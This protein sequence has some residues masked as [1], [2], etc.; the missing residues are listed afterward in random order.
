MQRFHKKALE[1]ILRD[2]CLGMAEVREDGVW[3]SERAIEGDPSQE[4][5]WRPV[6]DL[7]GPNVPD[8]LETPCLPIPFTASELAAFMLSG[9][10]AY[11]PSVYGDF[12][13]GPD[14]GML[15]SFGP[16]GIKAKEAL[17]TAY[18]AYR[19]AERSA[20]AFDRAPKIQADELADM[21]KKKHHEA[22]SREGVFESDI[23]AEEARER[24]ARASASV[25]HLLERFDEAKRVAD[26]TFTAW[27][28]AM[29]HQ[30][31]Q[32][33]AAPVVADGDGP[34][35]LTTAP[36]TDTAPPAPV[37]GKRWTPEKLAE[38][39]AY[40]EAHTMPET[41]VEF[42]ISEQRIR[43]LLP[44]QK[45]KAKPFAGLIHRTK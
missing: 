12:Q 4:L 11:L 26:S 45:P 30:L 28:K 44:S 38:L 29:V 37:G 14:E 15:A 43:E 20:G 2:N 3:P 6:C 1:L 24:R 13:D 41:A 40:R 36:A 9:I 7:D 39:K 5:L 33:Q 16:L 18:A 32:P 19:Q 10:G 8:P 42:G 34:V 23:S 27:R 22:K 21:Y 31:L 17:I 35:P 25:T